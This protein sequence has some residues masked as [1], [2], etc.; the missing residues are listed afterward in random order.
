[1]PIINAKR[2]R[3]HQTVRLAVHIKTMGR[4]LRST[5][6]GGFFFTSNRNMARRFRDK[7]SEWHSENSPQWLKELE[8]LGP[9][10]VRQ[11]LAP[12]TQQGPRAAIPIGQVRDVTKGY[13]LDWLACQDKRKV[14]WPKWGVI[15]GGTALTVSAIAL[16]SNNWSAIVSFI[17]A[18]AK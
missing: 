17:T 4:D 16:V 3:P 11:Y 12:Y 9:E 13:V 15:I 10:R 14:N 1:M 8:R 2:S 6:A 7:Q 18:H 5:L